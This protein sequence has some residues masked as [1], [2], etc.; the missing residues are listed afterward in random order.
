MWNFHSA[1]CSGRWKSHR[2]GQLYGWELIVILLTYCWDH[3]LYEGPVP[4]HLRINSR[5]LHQKCMC[6]NSQHDGSSKRSGYEDCC[7]V[8]WS[9]L[10]HPERYVGGSFWRLSCLLVFHFLWGQGEGVIFFFSFWGRR[11]TRDSSRFSMDALCLL[12][13][14]WSSQIWRIIPE[15]QMNNILPQSSGDFDLEVDPELKKPPDPS[16]ISIWRNFGKLC[17]SIRTKIMLISYIK[18]WSGNS[19]C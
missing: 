16:E 1:R 18:K 7:E 15:F 3:T 2:S 6:Y 5:L 9:C 17:I 8:E 19:N 14:F 11:W 10:P 13:M 12:L 4:T